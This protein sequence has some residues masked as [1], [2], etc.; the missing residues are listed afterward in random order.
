MRVTGP[1]LALVGLMG[2]VLAAPR[3]STQMGR[4]T[5]ECA[6]WDGPALG[7]KLPLTGAWTL[8]LAVYPSGHAGSVQVYPVQVQAG[9]GGADAWLSGPASTMRATGGTVWL[10]RF[11]DGVG[12][13]GRFTLALEDGQR[14]QGTFSARWKTPATTP[15]CG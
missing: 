1:L 6:P 2:P 14:L 4:I 15:L 11:V 3:S 9:T 12:A 7:L 8:T 13:A 5:A 10:D